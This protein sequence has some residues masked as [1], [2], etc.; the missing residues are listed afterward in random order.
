MSIAIDIPQ[1]AYKTWTLT[2]VIKDKDGRRDRQAEFEAEQ[3]LRETL[4]GYEY[5]GEHEHVGGGV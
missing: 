1:I 3:N 5:S 2:V 4:K